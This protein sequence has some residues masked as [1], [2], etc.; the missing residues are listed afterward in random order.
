M[1]GSGIEY[2][3]SKRVHLHQIAQMYVNYELI[4]ISYCG[5]RLCEVYRLINTCKRR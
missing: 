2:L 4:Q 5:W 3:A 1:L